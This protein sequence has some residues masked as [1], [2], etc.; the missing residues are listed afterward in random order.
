VDDQ[1]GLTFTYPSG[2]TQLPRASDAPES[3]TLMGPRVGAGAEP[4]TFAITLDVRAVSETTLATA[5]DAQLEGF[6]PEVLKLIQRTQGTACGEPAEQ[7]IGMP[8][9]AGAID[10][11]SLRK[12]KLFHFALTPYDAQIPTLAP[13]LTQVRAAYDAVLKSCQFVK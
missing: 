12:G 5:I 6:P 8:A 7:L 3:L 2:W 13:Y 10:T 9:L 11:F 4:F 1:L